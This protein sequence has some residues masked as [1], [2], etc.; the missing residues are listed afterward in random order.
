MAAMRPHLLQIGSSREHA[1]YTG[2]GDHNQPGVNTKI[3]FVR[4]SKDLITTMVPVQINWKR[5]LPFSCG[6]VDKPV[7]TGKSIPPLSQIGACGGA[8]MDWVK[9]D[10]QPW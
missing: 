2:V 4:G 8:V 6:T 9:E 3:A 1:N 7:V 5:N 10:R